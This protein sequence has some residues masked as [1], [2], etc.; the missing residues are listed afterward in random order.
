MVAPT[1][2]TSE[3]RSPIKDIYRAILLIVRFV[4]IDLYNMESV[5]LSL[6]VFVNSV[7]YVNVD[8]STCFFC[9]F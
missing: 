9:S 6:F 7:V 5:C 4:Y 8:V 1:L 3:K 2:R